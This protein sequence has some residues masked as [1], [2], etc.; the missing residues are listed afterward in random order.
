M[1]QRDPIDRCRPEPV[2]QRT[3]DRGHVGLALRPVQAGPPGEEY[4]R[5]E[6]QDK[7]FGF[8]SGMNRRKKAGDLTQGPELE[9]SVVQRGLSLEQNTPE[10]QHHAETERQRHRHGAHLFRCQGVGVDDHLG[11]AAGQ[12]CHLEPILEPRGG[13]HPGK[14]FGR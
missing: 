14:G 1:I 3:K 13:P 9:H 2:V 8:F 7:L 12:A 4:L 5:H 6:I 11:L 10:L